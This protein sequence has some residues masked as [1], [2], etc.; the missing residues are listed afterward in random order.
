MQALNNPRHMGNFIL[1]VQY[2]LD[3]LEISSLDM[4]LGMCIRKDKPANQNM[5]ELK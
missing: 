2:M 4:V 3:V 5:Q 1:D